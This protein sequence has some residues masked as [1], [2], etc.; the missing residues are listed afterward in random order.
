MTAPV[1]DDYLLLDGLRLHYRDWGDASAPPLILL[2]GFTGHAR[3]WDS[4]AST[5]VPRYRV[6]AL[7]QRGHGESG[8]T[9]DYST[10][11]MVGDIRAF[12]AALGLTSYAL[13]GLSMGGRNAIHFAGERPP[14]LERL[15]IVDIGPEIMA[16]GAA[17]IQEGVAANDS[18]AS[19][20]EA[21]ARG[22][23][24]NPRADEAELAHRTRHNLMR[25]PDGR[26]TFRYDRV[27]RDPSRPRPR[28]EA[29]EGWKLWANIAVPTLLVRGELSDI[30]APEVAA[31]MVAEHPDCR[32]VEVR[33]SGHSVPLEAP[34]AFRAAVQTFL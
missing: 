23:A 9:D 13:L 22:R 30:L 10:P 8:W 34:R 5:L 27:L 7:D 32:F 11:A 1:R 4:L 19:P 16:S 15:V 18:F 21:I 25:T 6:L 24:A 14:G 3:S 17:R 28:P 12:I 20:E 33:G 26:W 2:H 29:D 31:R